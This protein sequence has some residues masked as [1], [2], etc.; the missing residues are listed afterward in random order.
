M[1]AVAGGVPGEV[2]PHAEP[3]ALLLGGGGAVN[4]TAAEGNPIEIMDLSFAVQLA[5]LGELLRRR[6]APGV[7]ALGP[8]VDDLVAREALRARGA[9]IDAPRPV[10]PEGLDDWRSPRYAG[11]GR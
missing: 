7:H 4:I 2:A 8:E 9:E 11:G 10:D 6:P 3:G 1:I 5:A